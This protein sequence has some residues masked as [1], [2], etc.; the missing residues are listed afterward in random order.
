MLLNRV[1]GIVVAWIFSLI[2]AQRKR[3]E[4]RLRRTREEGERQIAERNTELNKAHEDLIDRSKL[5]ETSERQLQHVSSQ[6]LLA[7]E[8]ER[9]RI[10]NEIHDGL[11]ANLSALKYALES[12]IKKLK[13]GEPLD[14][15]KL[16]E[17]NS[18]LRDNI[19]ETRRIMTNLRPAMLDDL[20]LL[21]TIN[22]FCREYGKVY[23]HINIQKQIEIQESEIPDI[24]RIVIFRVLQEALNN[25][26]KHG[27]G[28]FV[29][30]TLANSNGETEFTIQDN[31]QGFDPTNCK[32]GLG[33]DSMRERVE[34]SGGSYSIESSEGA[35]T[36]IRALWPV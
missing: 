2:L 4:E 8:M 9:K 11:T 14:A 27:K 20:G 15:T 21:P 6:L 31:G 22:W 30:I 12:K 23:T 36:T 24:L 33:L 10:A 7:Q 28:N 13:E 25:F 3:T 18:R 5:L 26:A 34:F 17:I 19:D 35:G 1:M 16:E 32:K 29:N